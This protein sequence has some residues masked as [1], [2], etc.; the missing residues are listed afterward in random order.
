[1]AEISEDTLKRIR[2][3]YD[4]ESIFLLSD[5]PEPGVRFTPTGAYVFDIALGGG[6]PRGRYT[7]IFG[8]DGSGKTTLCQHIVANAQREGLVCMFMDVENSVDLD[9]MRAC[10]VDV[11]AL[12]F[13][14]PGS[15]EEALG[16]AEVLIN[17]GE[18]GVIVIDSIA[19]LSP[20]AESEK[21]FEDKNVTAMRRAKLLNVFF[22]RTCRAVRAKNVA[23]VFTNQLIDNTK[24]FWGGTKQPG[25]RGIK[26]YSS[27]R[28][29]LKRKYKGEI[30]L[31][32]NMIGQ[33]IEF[34][35]VKNKVSEPFK[36]GIFTIIFGR[37]LDR[38]ANILEAAVLLG[39][40]S[41][42]GAFYVYE[43]ETIAKGR[44]ACINTLQNNPEMIE[45]LDERCRE[46]ILNE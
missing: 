44:A 21:E 31:G 26:H 32:D 45:L 12:Y 43:G 2:K 18:V 24:S 4:D 33:D 34:N 3:L 14:Q 46:V 41:K 10:G 27:M 28:I 30:E 37:G 17:S 15:Q 9:Y 11:D 38:A 5:F 16:I 22:R 7:E 36:S 25:G 13:S 35:I 23:V 39:V 8:E 20:A 19:A 1:L 40:V 6:I 29:S 42:R